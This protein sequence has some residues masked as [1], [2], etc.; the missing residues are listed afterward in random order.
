MTDPTST[1]DASELDALLGAYALD[2]LD[3]VDR[4]AVD[5]Y[6]ERNAD[7]RAEVDEMRETAASLAL[8]PD[9]PTDAPPELWQRIA[10]VIATDDAPDARRERAAGRA[11]RLRSTSLRPDVTAPV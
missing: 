11:A 2:A 7:A 4:A 3:P 6:L 10:Q 8:L 1:P 5:A 9:T